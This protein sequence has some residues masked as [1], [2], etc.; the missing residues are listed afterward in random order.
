MLSTFRQGTAFI[1][2]RDAYLNQFGDKYDF[3][4]FCLAFIFTSIEFK[5]GLLG[6][7]QIGKACA[8]SRPS[9]NIGFVTFLNWNKTVGTYRSK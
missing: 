6:L 4:G 7:S 8:K 2:R 5:E 3:S 1:K 9:R